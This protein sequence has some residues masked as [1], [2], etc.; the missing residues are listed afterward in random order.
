MKRIIK[1]S[2]KEEEQEVMAASTIFTT[3]LSVTLVLLFFNVPTCSADLPE[4]ELDNSFPLIKPGHRKSVSEYDMDLLEFSMNLE[5][6]QA[7]FFLWGSL[8]QGLD[9]VAPNLAM[10]GPAPV[11]ARKANLDALTADIIT[12][13]GYQEVGHLR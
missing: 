8:G 5:Y 6:L 10:G 3:A 9:N 11:G 1:K 4:I 2:G 12:Q 13:F 7:E